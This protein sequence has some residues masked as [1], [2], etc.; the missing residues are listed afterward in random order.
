MRLRKKTETGPA[1]PPCAHRDEWVP[2][3]LVF[4]GDSEH[5]S[6]AEVCCMECGWSGRVPFSA[7]TEEG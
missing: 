4:T 6:H 1:A 2:C 7:I 5:P 3:T